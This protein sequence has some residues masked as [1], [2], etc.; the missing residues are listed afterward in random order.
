M[1]LISLLPFSSEAGTHAPASSGPLD[2]TLAAIPTS[3]SVSF[4]QNAYMQHWDVD[5]GSGRATSNACTG[6]NTRAN[7]ETTLALDAKASKVTWTR[8]TTPFQSKFKLCFRESPRGNGFYPCQVPRLL[9]WAISPPSRPNSDIANQVVV[10]M[11]LLDLAGL[12]ESLIWSTARKSNPPETPDRRPRQQ[13]MP[14][15]L[16]SR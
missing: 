12:V 15:L 10:C 16:M 13:I 6:I 2:K 8:P 7:A 11:Y 5:L 9:D 14:D 3:L 4:A 1:S